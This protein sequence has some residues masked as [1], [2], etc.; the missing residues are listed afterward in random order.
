M[1][2]NAL[3]I[4]QEFETQL[5][6]KQRE[7]AAILPSHIDSERFRYSALICVRDNPDLLNCDRRSLHQA[8]IEAAEDGLFPDSREGVITVYN[9][10]RN[11]KNAQGVTEEIWVK[12]ANWNPMVYGLRKRARELCNLILEAQ[13]VYDKDHFVWH[14]GDDPRIEHV[15]A[16]LGTPRG[17]PIGVYAIFREAG[18]PVLHREVLDRAEVEKIKS[19]SKQQNG[20]LW[21]KF[22]TE[23]WKKVAVRR[24]IKTVPSVPQF[25]KVVSRED[26][27]FDFG[28]KRGP[29]ID[30]APQPPAIER[31]QQLHPQQDEAMELIAE[32]VAVAAP[33]APAQAAPAPTAAGPLAAYRAACEAALTADA[34]NAVWS[35]FESKI[36]SADHDEALKIF[37][38]AFERISKGKAA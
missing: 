4:Y 12:V 37:E 33:Q 36:K 18:G 19:Q 31:P 16:K 28:N 8:L 24:G 23:A 2:S 10:K 32:E 34:L 15:P 7:Y 1:T 26:R 6:D 17:E 13:I 21:T 22:W 14:Q 3:Q 11:I 25:Q 20:L 27:D 29:T 30:A 5:A 9:E 35:T 38:G